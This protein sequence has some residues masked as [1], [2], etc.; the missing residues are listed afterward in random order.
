MSTHDSNEVEIKFLVHHADT[1]VR[2]LESAGFHQKTPSTFE[3]NTLYDNAAG[4]LRRAGEVLRLRLY[5]DQWRLTHKSR[6]TAAR[7]K[8]RVEHETAVADGDEMHA[9]LTDLGFRPS[10]RYEKYRAEW[11]DGEGELVIDRTPIG[12]LAEIEGAPQWIDR[13]AKLLGISQ[14]DYITESY[15]ELFSRWKQRTAS[16]ALNM[17]FDECRT[18]RPQPAR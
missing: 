1:L 3:A 11:S 6:G 9:I 8:T 7:H 5:G 4:D 10:F 16:P 15:A 12:D 18:P 17:T 13:I 14:A 2:S